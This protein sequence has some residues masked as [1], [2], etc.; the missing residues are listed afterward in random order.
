MDDVRLSDGMDQEQV[1]RLLG[2]SRVRVGQIER[3]AFR[4]IRKAIV[5][6]GYPDL[7]EEYAHIIHAAIASDEA[8]HE[9]LLMKQ[10]AKRKEKK[11]LRR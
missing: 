1:A 9:V 6:G 4:K 10:R 5:S 11:G 7:Y 3:S 2:V 8:E